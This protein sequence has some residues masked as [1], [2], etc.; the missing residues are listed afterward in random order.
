MENNQCV[1]SGG[2]ILRFPQENKA[3]DSLQVDKNE[4]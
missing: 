2:V 1:T 4:T 3:M